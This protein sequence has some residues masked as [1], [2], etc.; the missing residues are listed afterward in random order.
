MRA[1]IDSREAGQDRHGKKH[2]RSPP[3]EKPQARCDGERGLCMTGWHRVL[4]QRLP[5]DVNRGL[6][7]RDQIGHVLQWSRA[8]DQNFDEMPDHPAE[9]QGEA[10]KKNMRPET[11]AVKR[12]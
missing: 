11:R 10:Q 12:P 2:E 4:A 5:H 9:D 8:V 3:V 6:A 7:R 1:D